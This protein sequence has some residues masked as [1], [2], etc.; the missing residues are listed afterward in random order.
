MTTLGFFNVGGANDLPFKYSTI[1]R[2]TSEAQD[3]ASFPTETATATNCVGCIRMNQRCAL[4][5]GAERELCEEQ[6]YAAVANTQTVCD[7]ST[8]VTAVNK[9][10]VLDTR[11]CGT[12][13]GCAPFPGF[14][15]GYAR[16]FMQGTLERLSALPFVQSL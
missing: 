6:R 13:C 1:P 2:S 16:P 11:L 10:D 9:R 8:S 7:V 14:G 12:R 4:L 15:G 3:L 5:R